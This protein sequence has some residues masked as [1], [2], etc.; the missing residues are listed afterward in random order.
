MLYYKGK[1]RKVIEAVKLAN[2][3]LQEKSELYPRIRAR[4]NF[5][6]TEATPQ[7]IANS[8]K[9]VFK[10]E[11]TEVKLYW[12]WWWS[13]A[14]GYFD[15]RKPNQ[16]NTASRYVNRKTTDV[17]DLAGHF[18]HEFVHK[19]DYHD[20]DH[21]FGHAFRHHNKRHLSAPYWIGY[22][23]AYLLRKAAK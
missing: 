12:S 11:M 6:N 1:N 4:E 8:M 18:V 9:E 13:R 14:I 2:E 10:T 19:V 17:F 22:M 3:M 15:S 20:D 23:A 5:H 21:R 7:A 16:I